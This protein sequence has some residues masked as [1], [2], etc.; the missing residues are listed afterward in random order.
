MGAADRPGF[1]VVDKPAGISSFAVVAR[2]R[3]LLGIKRIGHLGTLDPFATGLLVC[4]LGNAT[5]L[6]QYLQGGQKR[7]TGTLL[8]GVASSTDDI[9]GELTAV[10]LPS[11]LDLG[12]LQEVAKRLTGEIMQRPPQVSA[13][14]VAGERAYKLARRGEQMELAARAVLVERFELTALEN[15]ADGTARVSYLVDCGKGTYIRSLAR[16]LGE[17]LGTAACVESLRRERSEPFSLEQAL[18]LEQLE[19][20]PTLPCMNWHTPFENL[21]YLEVSPPELAKLTNGC[22]GTLEAVGLRG[23][24]RALSAG[25]AGDRFLIRVPALS[26]EPGLMAFS[27]ERWKLVMPVLRPAL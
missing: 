1:V 6:V 2:L 16:D 23:R 12:Q 10:S 26:S 5:R 17:Q 18:T 21:L 15:L 8:L 11:A 14:H 24:E 4:A 22:K 25:Q 13:V 20:D 3:R 9:T 7:Y 27:D 19:S